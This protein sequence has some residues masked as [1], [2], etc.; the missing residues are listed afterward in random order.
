MQRLTA[1]LSAT[2][3]AASATAQLSVVIPNGYAATEGASSNAFPW[4]RGGAGGLREQCIYDSSHFTNQGITYPILITGLKYRPNTGVALAAV[5][6]TTATVALST[7][8]VDQ[9]AVSTNVAANEGADLATVYSG[10]V[11]WGAQPAQTGPTPFG[12]SVP[13]TTNFLYD[14]SLGD[15]NIESDLPTQTGTWTS[16]QLDVENGTTTALGS[17]VF[18]SNTY[19]SGPGTINLNHAVVVEVDYVPATGLHAAFSSSV[20]AGASPLAVSFTDHTFTS[21]PVGVTSWA[22]DFNGDG[23]TDSTLQNPTF[24]YN[25]CGNFNVSLTVT[26]ASHPADTLTRTGFIRIDDITPSFTYSLIG[27]PN[28]FQFTDTSTPPATAWAWD[29]NNDGIVDSTAQNP[30]ALMPLCQASTVRL[31]ATRNCKTGTTTQSTIFSPASLTTTLV[32]GNSGASNYTVYFDANVTNPQGINLCGLTVVSTTIAG[33]AFTLDVYVTPGTYVGVD[34]TAAAWRL[35]GSAAGTTNA[36]NTP[37][38]AQMASPVYLTSGSHGIAIRYRGVTPAYTNGNG[39]NQSYSNADLA[40]TLGAA[41]NTT[42]A[43]F[44]GATFLSP[45]VWNGTLHYDTAT[46]AATAGYGFF[47]S[48]CASSLGISNLLPANRPQ[49]GTTLTVNVNNLPLSAAVMMVGFSNTTS[50]FGPLPLDLAPLGAPGCSGR[51]S[52]DVTLFLSGAANAA[53]WALTVPNVPTFIGTVLYNQAL[54]L[55]PAINALGAVVSDAA[56][57]MIGN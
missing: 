21:D 23:I 15:L 29:F 22:W 3:L 9:S 13:F 56:G 12:I 2:I 52:P 30:V 46:G 42:S 10:P 44:T 34:T 1:V 6:Y 7:C 17:R 20:T 19:P 53:T 14:P 41:R 48:G 45:R 38:L 8:P 37:S 43:P 57:M 26:D 5:G 55:D 32:A 31:T 24:V 33:T 11:S 36:P 27:P 4:G 16:F 28:V 35:V 54:V 40:L 18:I 50:G 51:V 25:T 47:G 39:S 49:V